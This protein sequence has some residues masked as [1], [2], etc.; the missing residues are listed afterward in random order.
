M[1][2]EIADA[3]YSVLCHQEAARC[4]APGGNALPF[5]ARCTGVYAG[6]A[7][8]VCLAPLMRFR[9]GRWALAVHG[10]FLI[11]M[12]PFGFHLIP[13]PATV[14]TLSGQL[15]AIGALFFLW[16]NLFRR[17]RLD[18]SDRVGAP[19]G[20]RYGYGVALSLVLLQ[21]L[22]RAPFSFAQGLL[23]FLAVLGA[24][25]LCVTAALTMY[26]LLFSAYPG[27]CASPPRR[28][29]RAGPSPPD[30]AEPIHPPSPE[31]H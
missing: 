7:L 22:V 1:L 29:V 30:H 24:A 5:C 17:W 11:Q 3:V 15:F 10:F 4:W 13:H 26:D 16:R 19:A 6:A 31:R 14:R 12:V 25:A 27:A 18:R 23:E 28:T 8:A 21:A 2:H 20:R 9:P